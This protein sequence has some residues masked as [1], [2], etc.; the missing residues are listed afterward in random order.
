MRGRLKRTA[1][2]IL[3]IFAIVTC[4]GQRCEVAAGTLSDCEPSKEA[5]QQL[6]DLQAEYDAG[7]EAIRKEMLQTMTEE[8]VS[9]TLWSNGPLERLKHFGP[10]FLLLARENPRTDVAW[11]SLRFVVYVRGFSS[12]DKTLA[13]EQML[14]DHIDDD[15]F[16]EDL[17]SHL[18]R[19]GV[20]TE[21][22]YRAVL[23]HPN[24][25]RRVVGMAR[26]ALGVWLSRLGRNKES[27]AAAIELF[28]QVAANFAD[29][30][31]PYD[32]KRGTLGDAARRAAF[33]IE[34]LCV[35][36]AAP[37]ISG[38]DVDGKE[39][40]LSDYRGKVV[41]LVFC[42][43]W[44][45][46][47]RSLYPHEKELMKRL[48]N[49]PFAIVGVNSDAFETLREAIAREEFPFRWFADG[50][51]RGPISSE[52]NIES[53]PTIYVLDKTGRIAFRSIGAPKPD[54]IDQAVEQ[55]LG[56]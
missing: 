51:T 46:P 55:L 7:I 14:R 18:Y 53:W 8:Q 15:Q 24:A 33:E 5:K 1:L 25:P 47:C 3:A 11:K 42:G 54:E 32:Q 13:L 38:R 52:W 39:F 31:H 29:L 23:E 12:R 49:Q 22:F 40:R 43:E 9:E 2:K 48:Q 45:G 36:K 41:L 56:R 21:Q 37:E 19:P 20:N 6:E 17:Y 10:R 30:P 27:E 44:C 16:F 50:S 35:G 26:F 4:V 28:R 34:H